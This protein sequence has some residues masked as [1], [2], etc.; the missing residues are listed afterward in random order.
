MR[1]GGQGRDDGRTNAPR[2]YLEPEEYLNLAFR[3]G[4]KPRDHNILDAFRRL[5]GVRANI[6]PEE[7]AATRSKSN[8]RIRNATERTYRV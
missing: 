7:F 6:V 1:P 3:A 2:L 8:E 4:F 5:S